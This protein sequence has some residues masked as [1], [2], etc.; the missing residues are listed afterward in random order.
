MSDQTGGP[1]VLYVVL[2]GVI[3]LLTGLG[4]V[5]ILYLRAFRTA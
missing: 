5:V 2:L 3:G 1:F 4:G